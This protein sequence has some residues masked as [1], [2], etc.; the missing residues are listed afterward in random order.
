MFS[1]NDIYKGNE[2]SMQ[3]LQ[4]INYVQLTYISSLQAVHRYLRNNS[5]I[6]LEKGYKHALII[7]M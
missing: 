2:I 3:I 7:R 4:C 6:F 1:T 5:F